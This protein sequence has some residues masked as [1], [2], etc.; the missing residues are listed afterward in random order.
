MPVA[1]VAQNDVGL[2]AADPAERQTWN[3]NAAALTVLVGPS[4]FPKPKPVGIE[5]AALVKN[6]DSMTAF[7]GMPAGESS[8]APQF[9]EFRIRRLTI[10]DKGLQSVES[11]DST[12]VVL[13]LAQFLE[14]I[15]H[16]LSG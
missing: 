4:F 12:L 3:A 2:V 16:E 11:W 7:N 5:S 13:M 8:P 14:L 6:Q 1:V 9:G 15:I 10:C